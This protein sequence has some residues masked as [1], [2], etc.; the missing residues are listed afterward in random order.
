[1]QKEV[2]VSVSCK[3]GGGDPGYEVPTGWRHGERGTC[4][5]LSRTRCKHEHLKHRKHSFTDL[6]SR[7]YL[8]SVH[9]RSGSS[10]AVGVH[11]SK[12]K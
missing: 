3:D 11:V 6:V 8:Q 5:D 10:S 4:K 1:M 9:Y 7:L 12:G 2:G